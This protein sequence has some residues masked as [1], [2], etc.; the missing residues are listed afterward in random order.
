M[1]NRRGVDFKFSLFSEEYVFAL[2]HMF[3]HDKAW[4]KN[5][6]LERMN[7]KKKSFA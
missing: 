2:S 4:M 7:K 6:I 1:E 5:E 3:F